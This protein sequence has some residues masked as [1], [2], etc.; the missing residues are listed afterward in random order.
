MVDEA[1]DNLTI[2]ELDEMASNGITV[3]INNGHITK[4][5]DEDLQKEE[6]RT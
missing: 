1:L 6:S 3:E 2:E 5:I 4:V